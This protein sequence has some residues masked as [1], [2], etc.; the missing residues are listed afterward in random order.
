MLCY[1]VTCPVLRYLYMAA[2]SKNK[3]H[4]VLR[5][6]LLCCVVLCYVVLCCNVIWHNMLFCDVKLC[7]AQ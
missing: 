3:S 4:C 2:F 5:C 1:D 7:S 6:T